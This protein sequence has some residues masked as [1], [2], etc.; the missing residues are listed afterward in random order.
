MEWFNALV[1]FRDYKSPPIPKDTPIVLLHI[2]SEPICNSTLEVAC[3]SSFQVGPFDELVAPLASVL[4]A[5]TGAV[6]YTL[7]RYERL[8]E[9]SQ[10]KPSGEQPGQQPYDHMIR[11]QLTDRGIAVPLG[12]LLSKRAIDEVSSQLDT[13]QGTDCD[14]R[15]GVVNRCGFKAIG[16][17]VTRA[18]IN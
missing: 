4:A 12:W 14:D 8:V 10:E 13:E 1:Y 16:D 15:V 2:G 7:R 11:L 17:A 5:R 3:V 6:D 9:R 18:S